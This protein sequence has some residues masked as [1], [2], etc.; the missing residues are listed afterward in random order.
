MSFFTGVVGAAKGIQPTFRQDF[1]KS[2][3]LD[4]R[5]TFSRNSIATRFNSAGVL[6]TLSANQ[7]RFDYDPVTLAAKGVKLEE[8]RQNLLLQSEN[9]NNAAWTKTGTVVT[10]GSYV[11]SN[12]IS[13]SNIYQSTALN[14]TFQYLQEVS[15]SALA[16]TYVLSFFI[17]Y[18]D[19][20]WVRFSISNSAGNNAARAYFDLQNSVFGTVV[21]AGTA[22][23]V[24]AYAEA[25]KD[26]V[27]R[28]VLIGTLSETTLRFAIVLS[29]TNNSFGR[30]SE[31]NFLLS[32]P[33]LGIGSYATSYIPTTTAAVTRQADNAR[34]TGSNLTSFY[35]PSEGTFV[36]EFSYEQNSSDIFFLTCFNDSNNYFAIRRVNNDL[37][38]IVRKTGSS[39]GDFTIKFNALTGMYRVVFSYDVSSFSACVSGGTVY[40]G[41]ANMVT[42]PSSVYLGSLAGSPNNIVNARYLAYY[43]KALPSDQLQKLSSLT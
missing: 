33:Q 6:E 31:G 40:S 38:L 26:G 14:A 41:A 19:T 36:Y 39:N 34:I 30:P 13:M 3:V 24:T 10:Q 15:G 28:I 2:E 7:F 23:G 27:Y 5:I 18:V 12:G 22:T 4:P 25:Y 29:D 16:T 21:S 35:N 32:S 11:S 20:R 17:K 37:R 8:S 43:P 1:T 9:L 42:S